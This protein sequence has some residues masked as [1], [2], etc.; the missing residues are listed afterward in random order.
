MIY[1]CSILTKK[2]TP[3]IYICFLYVFLLLNCGQGL[4]HLKKVPIK[5]NYLSL[6][7]IKLNSAIKPLD[8]VTCSL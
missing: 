4:S 7:I 2:S 8:I 3:R 5:C 6:K 1:L